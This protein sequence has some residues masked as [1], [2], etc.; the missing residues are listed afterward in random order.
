MD[1]SGNRV[2]NTCLGGFSNEDANGVRFDAAG[3]IYVAGF[4]QSIDFP[5]TGAQFQNTYNG[6][7]DAFVACFTPN[8][9]LY[10]ATF[11]GSANNEQALA[12]TV[13]GKYIY[14]GGITDSPNFPITTLADQDSIA[15]S[16]DGFYCK[17]DTAGNW[18]ASSFFGGSQLDAIYGIA[19]T[20]DTM[21]YLVGNTFSNNLPTLPGVWQP[22]YTSLG[23][24]FVAMRDVSEE[25]SG[26]TFDAADVFETP[27]LLWPNPAG[28][29]L[30]LQTETQAE[31]IEIRDA[32]GRLVLQQNV[33]ANLQSI[34]TSKLASGVYLASVFFINGEVITQKFLR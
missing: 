23:D 15:G 10:W 20:A 6:S 5:V 27:L 11:L 30:F 25:L 19:I 31:R 18:V 8:Y 3:N 14:V 26:N 16:N 17:L 28:A 24:A 4:T 29:A 21:A 2:Y 32:A 12:L 33:S 13:S 9:Q 22:T 7:S 34:D 1:S